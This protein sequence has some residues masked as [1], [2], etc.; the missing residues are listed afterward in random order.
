MLRPAS[1]TRV[2]AERSNEGSAKC[3]KDNTK[4]RRRM[5]NKTEPI[6]VVLGA[7]MEEKLWFNARGRCRAFISERPRSARL[8]GCGSEN[9]RNLTFKGGFKHFMARVA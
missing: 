3:L 8:I 6:S 5:K 9:F 2:R 4:Q 7:T 1:C